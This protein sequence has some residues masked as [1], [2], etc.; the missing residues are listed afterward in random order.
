MVGPWSDDDRYMVSGH[1][2]QKLED[3]IRH[4]FDTLPALGGLPSRPAITHVLKV[5]AGSSTVFG[6]P[7]TV[8]VQDAT[9]GVWSDAAG[10]I[11]VRVID[12]NGGI[13]L[14]GDYLLARSAN[15]NDSGEGCFAAISRPTIQSLVFSGAP[16]SFTQTALPFIS[17][18]TGLSCTLPSA[19]T[20][21]IWC[22]VQGYFFH[23][24]ATTY[25]QTC[26]LR[27]VGG[28]LM[29]TN[30]SGGSVNANEAAYH[31]VTMIYNLVTQG[32]EVVSLSVSR[33]HTLG[34]W[35][36][37]FDGGL[38]FRGTFGHVLKIA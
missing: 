3:I 29:T 8:Q 34:N 5:L 15:V 11:Q 35:Q 6:V 24:A 38:T 19:G 26:Q 33:N 23:T 9:T 18:A 37:I 20:Y 14:A 16:S 36:I 4:P 13:L 21:L 27:T 28:P 32:S 17:E 12:P 7:A 30:I 1:T 10:P 2:K 31:S 25:I 22:T